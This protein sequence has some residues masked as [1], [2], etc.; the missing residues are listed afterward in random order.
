MWRTSLAGRLDLAAMAVASSPKAP[1]NTPI[2]PAG[3][4]AHG[5]LY[6][7]AV[8]VAAGLGLPDSAG[9]LVTQLK[10]RQPRALDCVPDG[11]V[12]TGADTSATVGA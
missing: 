2:I 8:D 7:V 4:L 6:V 1:S 10:L 3:D 9:V 11:A 5:A 12:V